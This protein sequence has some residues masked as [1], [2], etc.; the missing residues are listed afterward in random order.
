MADPF[1]SFLVSP[2]VI[3]VDGVIDPEYGIPIAIDPAGDGN[4][5]AAMDLLE[6]YVAQDATNFY[7][8][9]TINANVATTNWGKYA[10]YI[11]TDNLA[12]SGA[13]SDAWTRNLVVEDPHRPEY[14]LY[15][16][17]DCTPYNA[18]CTQFWQW[19]GNNWSQNGALDEA[20]LGVG[21]IS[22]LEWRVSKSRLGDPGAIWLEVWDTGGGS[23]DN[24][25]DT[26]NDP[27]DDWNATDW[28]TSAFL[29]VS[30]QYPK[31][32]PIELTVA[33]PPEGYYSHTADIDITG[34]VSP[35]VGVTVTVDMNAS[36]SYTPTIEL[37]GAFTQPVT[38][39]RGSNTLTIT[40]TDG[41]YTTTV[42]RHVHH[43]ASHDNDIFWNELG[44][45]SRDSLYR[46]PTGPLETTTPVTL[47]LR[48][49][50]GDLTAARV[51]L[52]D[53]RLDVQTFHNM[54]I[55]ADDGG[56]EWWEV[57]LPASPNP[58]I[59][60]Y[61][62]I[63][64]D[65]TDV[66]YYED[67]NARTGGW[68]Q[69]FDESVDNSWQLSIF[70]PAFQTPD[71]IKNAIV[72]Q[73]FPDRF[74]DGDPSNE[75]PPG[76]FFY[77]EAGG[78]IFRS[79]PNFGTG[80]PW[81]TYVCD[82][83]DPNDCP[84]TWSKNF[85]GGDLQG[86]ID[87]LD[88]LQELGV[89]TIYL[90]P[91]F[92]SPSNHK[93]DTNDFSAIDDNFGNLVLFQMLISQAHSRGINILL[94]GVFN[95]TSSDS[96]YF[97]RYSRWDANGNPT[98]PGQNDGSGACESHSSPYRNWYY[99]TDITPGTGPCVGSDGTPN[100]ATY[101]SWWGYD[102]LPVLNSSI[103]DV[104]DF[105]WAGGSV[106]IAPYWVQWSDG[107]RLDVGGD[108][109]P[110]T[111]ND[112]NND[113]WEG[114]RSAVHSVNPNAYI[115]GEEWGNATSWVLGGE[116]DAVMNYQYSSAMLSFWRDEDFVDNDH[117][118]SSSAGT[119]TPLIPSEL[120]ERLL[121]W[122][123]RY[124][125]E[126]LYAMLNLLGSHDTN[127]ALFMLDHNTDL[128]NPSLY[129]NPDYD[130]SDAIDRLKG[131]VLLQFTLP[132]APTIYYG[133]EVGL[134]GPVAHDGNV[135]QDDPYNRQPYPWLDESGTP[136]YTHLQTQ[137]EQDELRD[138]YI[139]L[140]NARNTHPALRTGSFETLLVDD[141]NNIYAFG[142]RLIGTPGDAAIVIIN[143]D[144]SNAQT[145]T[146]DI[147]GYLPV[148]AVFTDVLDLGASYT[149][150]IDRELTIIDIPPMFGS[151]L[152]LESGDI[153]PP[154][155]PANLIAEEGESFVG[156][157]WDLVADA[158]SYNIYRSL[159]S[160]GGYEPISNTV[161]T[162]FTDT[163]VTN[164][165][166]YYYVVTAVSA[167]GME[168]LYSN[169]ASALPHWD[170]DWANLQWPAEITH[171]IGL[172]PTQNISGQVYIS[173]VTSL[174]GTTPGLIAQLGF[175]MTSS[176]PN[177]WEWWFDAPFSGDVG[178]NDEFAQQLIPEYTGDF[179]YVYRY[180]T[181][182]GRDWIYAD[183]SGIFAGTPPDP[184]IL[185]VLPSSDTTPPETPSNLHIDDWGAEYLVL[186]WE[187]V[188]GDPTMYAYDLFRAE[189]STT[190]GTKIARILDPTTIY[191]DSNL[192]T[193]QTYYYV[194]QALDTSFNRSG[195]SN[196]VVG[197]PEP[198]KVVVTFNV[199]VPDFT[200]GTVYI[201]GD[202]AEIGNWN[203]A[204][205]P[206]SPAGI[207]NTWTIT[208]TFLDGT[209]IEYK[210][211]RGSWDMVEKEA[212]G[213]GEIT[214]RQ[215]TVNYGIDGNQ[216][217]DLTVANWRDPIV[218]SHSPA[219]D[220]TDVPTDTIISVTWSQ[221]MTLY[222]D[223]AVMGP[224]GII[225]GVFS[226]DPARLTTSF[227]PDFP[228]EPDTI[229][230]V[231]VTGQT[232]IVGDIQQVPVVWSF[233]TAA[234][235]KIYLAIVSRQ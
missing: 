142:R 73:I 209:P 47:R 61:R 102:S 118:A 94:D 24:A 71:W 34:T 16:W 135:W 201:V 208:R 199:A 60:W 29:L 191:T 151:V 164:G 42:V 223:Y 186:S 2:D 86:L 67:D 185:H 36:A 114:F 22:V 40:A 128:E 101:T 68:G 11:D 144:D 183:L 140:T 200:P 23:N 92:E 30:T 195:Y 35:T 230:T 234:E 228:L 37:T 215:L 206:M 72:Y 7:F 69:P 226:Y 110:G 44:H 58:T 9:F 21:A 70:D 99:F 27:A 172:T 121:N 3:I 159:V 139:L 218:V 224:S 203:P 229:Y 103:P 93:Y 192:T 39:E 136:F 80:N 132:G 216:I 210:F 51:R 235:N 189:I 41:D 8:A 131:V 62:F 197:I 129:L 196:Q 81:N 165:M 63:A 91:I 137:P 161:N 85:Y 64:I 97:D 54:H 1:A 156:L 219:P 109:D 105:I 18:S 133:D 45:N 100:A 111:I 104:R 38:L 222:T 117:S 123:E 6:L 49:A 198:K 130:W 31:N 202:H 13:T 14:G 106:A 75:T 119:L 207:S 95:H 217:V 125:P 89:T 17:V 182:N 190:I 171:T 82:P 74:R 213:N 179:Y 158:G 126:A 90:N 26:I 115:V 84:G 154:D 160:G 57:T 10:I 113:Y 32:L 28:T 162:I 87:K 188:A 46:T 4:G 98:T 124:P 52:W 78:T 127:R 108:I 169:E 134:V 5:N 55:V 214:N 83:R 120:D 141:D 116:W 150:N 77:N 59:Y 153:T 149:V 170:I 167:T 181:T 187:P 177:D 212:D 178:D 233:Q 194:V 166:L 112:P 147:G 204:A 107:W 25:Q 155:P 48:A 168:S 184:G 225:S 53:D 221:S 15:S 96:I 122:M 173:G 231:T 33:F 232:D 65:G 66:D 211:T 88:Y 176:P 174:P 157:S 19:N 227:S 79:D 220:A 76:T 180:S 12:G 148:G 145:V 205:I 43:G 146:V 163:T 143:R 20:A 175:G 138:H 152:V 193:G 56:Y 50:S